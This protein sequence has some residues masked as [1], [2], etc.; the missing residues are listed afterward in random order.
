MWNWV[1]HP[2]NLRLAW[3]RVE[4]NRGARSA[5][6]DIPITRCLVLESPVHN[7]RCTPGSEGGGRKPA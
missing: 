7:E 2:R 1:T 3:R 4:T 5:G 6:V